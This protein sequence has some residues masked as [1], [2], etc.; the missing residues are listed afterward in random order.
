MRSKQTPFPRAR[1]SK[2][3]AV[4]SAADGW[5]PLAQ[6][7]KAFEIDPPNLLARDTLF[8]YIA[9]YI[10]YS[11]CGISERGDFRLDVHGRNSSSP[12]F[13]R[14]ATQY[15]PSLGLS[16]RMGLSR[17]STRRSVVAEQV[18]AL[19]SGSFNEGPSRG[20]LPRGAFLRAPRRR[21]LDE[22]A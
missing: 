11:Q 15:I 10:F 7:D 12:K 21:V 18:W 13:R 17:C 6:T 3:G 20:A 8:R 9:S 16:T 22:R 14:G 1:A 5:T 19:G 2:R 4:Q